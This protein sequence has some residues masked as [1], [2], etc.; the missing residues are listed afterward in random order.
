MKRHLLILVSAGIFTFSQEAVAFWE[1]S[2]TDST[3]G[4]NV[5]A[6]FDVNTVT[7]L[8]G[9]VVKPPQRKDASQ[10]T[11]MSIATDHGNVTVVLGPWWFW[12]NQS[13]TLSRDQEVA[14]TGSRA[15]GK[16][17]LMYLF[18]QR[19]DNRSNGQSVILRSESG[20]PLWAG[21]GSGKG[22][23]KRQNAGTSPPLRPD[24]PNGDCPGGRR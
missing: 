19:I 14:I 20:A 2:A 7:T 3:S 5:A 21:S 15:Q 10:H 23:G 4:L 18:A 17:G 11:E 8:N 13:I 16:D 12:K 24:C 1:N 9:R 22:R 6:G